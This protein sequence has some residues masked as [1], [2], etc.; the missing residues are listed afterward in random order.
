MTDSIYRLHHRDILCVCVLALLGLGVLMV[1]SATMRVTGNLRWHLSPDG[2]SNWSLPAWPWVYFCWSAGLITRGW[3]SNHPSKTALSP[4]CSWPRCASLRAGADPACGHADQRCPAMDQART[5]PI[6]TFRTGQVGGG[7]VSRRWLA[8]PPV[9]LDRF[10][11]GFVPTLIPIV[12]LCLLVVIQDF[13]TAAL[14]ACLLA[15]HADRR[16]GASSGIC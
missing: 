8:K 9:D 3:K 11:T 13:G 6:A 14:I 1:D 10:F 12:L 15:D 16:P 7:A 4:G 2:R 5:D